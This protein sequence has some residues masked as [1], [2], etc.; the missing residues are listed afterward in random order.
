MK[1]VKMIGLLVG[2][3][4]LLLWM[5]LPAGAQTK[6]PCA[7]DIA[8]FCKE[9]K[10][11][12]GRL[13]RCLKEHEA[14]LSAQC[15]ASIEEARTKVKEAHSACADDIQKLCKDVR[16][17]GGRIVRCLKENEGQLSP[18]CR[19]ELTHFRKKAE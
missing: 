12:G 3:L 1:S 7:N 14:E 10:P 19:D 5:G 15:K 9:V 4:G 17:G 11:G 8:Q 18:E 13:V 6:N 16:P 2:I